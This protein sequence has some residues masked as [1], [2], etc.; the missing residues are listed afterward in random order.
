MIGW[1]DRWTVSLINGKMNEFL[2][3][4]MMDEWMDGWEQI[5]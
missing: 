4:K 5:W 3:V 1:M 2:D